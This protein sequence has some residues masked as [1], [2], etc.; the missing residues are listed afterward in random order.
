MSSPP[1]HSPATRSPGDW[2]YL[3]SEIMVSDAEWIYGANQDVEM[4][5]SLITITVATRITII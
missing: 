1:A 5:K 2:G 3:R 4:S